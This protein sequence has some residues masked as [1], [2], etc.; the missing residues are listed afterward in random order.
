MSAPV[1]FD[2]PKPEELSELLSGYDVTDLIAT[3]GMGAVY[4]ANQISLERA[5]AIK[6]LPSELN[7]PTFREQFQA[8]ARAMAKLNHPNLIGIYDFGQAGDM[9][10]IVMELVNGKSLYYSSYGK[11]IDQTTACKI[12]IGI[13]RGLAHAHSAGIIHRDIKPANILLDSHANPKI[14]DFGLASASDTDN[15]G[16]PVFGT[17]GYAAPEILASEKNIGIPSDLFAVGIILYQ[18][19]TGKMPNEPASPPSTISSCDPRLDPIFRRATR[20]NPAMRCQSAADIADELDKLLPTLG[21]SAR[22][23]IRTGNTGGASKSAPMKRNT[24][25]TSSVKTS[26]PKPAEDPRR[27][28]L[29]TAASSDSNASKPKLTRAPKRSADSE[30]ADIPVAPQVIAMEPSSNWPIIRNLMIIAVLIPAI[31]FTWG[32]YQDKQARLKKE[33]DAQELEDK[34]S[35]DLRAAIYEKERRADEERIRLEKEADDRAKAFANGGTPNTGNPGM[36]T[37]PEPVT[38]TPL[39]QLADLKSR[40]VSGSRNTYPEGTI[41]R[42]THAIFFVESPMTWTAASQFA[43]EHGAHLATPGTNAD[44][45]VITKRMTGDLKRVWIGGGASARNGWSWVTGEEWAYRDPATTLGSCASLTSTGVIKARP[46]GEKNAFV[47]QWSADGSNPGALTSQLARLAPTL[48]TPGPAWPPTAVAQDNRV[49]LLVQKPVSWDEAD[50]IAGT[51]KGHLAVASDPLESLFIREHLTAS[52][53]NDES[54]WLGG[55]RNGGTWIWST[56]EPWKQASWQP[57]SPDGGPDDSALRF[58][59][60]SSGSGWDDISPDAGKVGSF[61]IEWSTDSEQATAD[62]SATPATQ[63]DGELAKHRTTGRRFVSKRKEEQLE[64]LRENQK[65]LMWD[66]STW[67]RDQ[68]KVGKDQYEAPINALEDSFATNGILPEG[69]PVPNLPPAAADYYAKARARQARFQKDFEESMENLRQGYLGKLLELR[70]K[71]E[72]SGQ[73]TQTAQVDEEIKGVGQNAAS[74]LANFQ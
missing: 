65:N 12:I 71:L 61:L 25:E 66:L 32:K 46:N 45:D 18:L 8:E 14:G 11:A 51:G 36:P 68:S 44:L 15:E 56:G 69:L 48:G 43:E 37:P 30:A 74:F 1:E 34:A 29:S 4:R 13:C 42:S 7:D 49:F 24:G 10:Y 58:V 9:P 60:S 23:A 26:S 72:A 16:G 5:V 57:S 63:G 73:K 31:I 53:A 33:R 39:E 22:T 62:G 20:R 2:P 28:K 35:A 21:K 64:K 27:R 3:G 52:L 38:K 54:A 6:L 67:L 47:I 55:R 19:L 41:D 40:L 17:P 70:D 59:K 50:F